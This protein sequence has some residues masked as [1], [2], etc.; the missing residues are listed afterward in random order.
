MLTF[1]K[2]WTL[3]IAM[4]LGV[5]AYLLF[6]HIPLLEPT[7]PFVST[8]VAY[9]TPSLI[10][11]QLLL[12]FCKIEPRELIPTLWHGWLLLFQFLSASLLPVPPYTKD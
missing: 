2:N 7:K 4:L 6:A 3:P 5:V 10:F 1:L 12:T 9:L 11:L 8:F